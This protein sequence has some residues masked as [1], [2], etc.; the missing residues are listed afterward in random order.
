MPK[1]QLSVRQTVTRLRAAGYDI[2]V[3]SYETCAHMGVSAA[4]ERPARW[5]G[6]LHQSYYDLPK[7]VDGALWCSDGLIFTRDD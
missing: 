5:S 2:V 7:K 1:K 4:V 6:P 3:G